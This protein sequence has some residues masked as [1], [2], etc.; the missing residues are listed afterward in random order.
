M[1]KPS[2]GPGCGEFNVGGMNAILILIGKDPR[3]GAM[4][5]ESLAPGKSALIVTG[6]EELTV[7]SRVHQK[8]FSKFVNWTR[9]CYMP[10]EKSYDTNQGVVGR[11]GLVVMRR[12]F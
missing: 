2:E 9:A 12:D 6:T 10:H 8:N 3:T 7:V 5:A 11:D 1:G 4:L